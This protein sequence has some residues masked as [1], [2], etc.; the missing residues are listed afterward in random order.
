MKRKFECW[1]CK[2]HF[3]ADDSEWVECPHCHSDNVEYASY[4]MP[5][6]VKW[7][8]PA[9]IIVAATGFGISRIDWNSRNVHDDIDT[10][11]SLAV[12]AYVRDTLF[13]SETGLDIPASIIVG[14][15]VFDEDGYS[16]EAGVKNPPSGEFHFVL[17]EA[18]EDKVV[19]KSE[20]GKF[21][22]IPFS[23]AEGGSYRIQ[24]RAEGSDSICATSDVPGFIKQMKVSK[25]M[26]IAELQ[27]KISKRDESLLGIGEN[28]Y[29]APDCQLKF[30]G[31]ARDAINIPQVLSEVF[32]KLNNETWAS[33]KVVSLEY[34]DMNR[35]S[36]ITMSVVT[37]D[38]DF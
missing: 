32:E 31:L 37:N 4:H 24:I 6:W 3:E 2:S 11:D 21:S 33:A 25:K 5:S 12:Q 23:K 19:A 30:T 16:F 36:Q 15:L 14:E 17:L 27:A 22:A 29:L 35:I 8:V 18:F 9:V 1:N 13:T 20:D 34:D 10:N 28:A 7:T 38:L 26:S